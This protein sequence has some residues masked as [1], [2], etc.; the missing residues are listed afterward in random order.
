[1]TMDILGWYNTLR[2]CGYYA[3]GV[4]VPVLHLVLA[5]AVWRDTRRRRPVLAGGAVWAVT[6]L[7]LGLPAFALYWAAHHS[8]WRADANSCSGPTPLG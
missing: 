7:V 6:T 1:M 3:L 8:T 5:L 2:T 4:I